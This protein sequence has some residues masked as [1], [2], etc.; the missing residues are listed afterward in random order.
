[1]ITAR[2]PFAQQEKFREIGHVLVRQQ[3][4]HMYMGADSVYYIWVEIVN[5]EIELAGICYSRVKA[6]RKAQRIAQERG[7]AFNRK[8]DFLVLG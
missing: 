1:V 8:Y 7:L 3:T 4:A 2:Y 5:Q 6:I